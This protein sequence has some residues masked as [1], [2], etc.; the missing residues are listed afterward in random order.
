M[1]K[2]E[3]DHAGAAQ[4]AAVQASHRG[5]V[6]QRTGDERPVE[7]EAG[8]EMSKGTHSVLQVLQAALT[9]DIVS[10]PLSF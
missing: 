10:S 1:T 8:G 6:Q 5:C 2:C 9:L 3:S 4:L 7:K